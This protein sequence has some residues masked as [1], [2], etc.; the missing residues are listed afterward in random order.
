M[1]GGQQLESNELTVQNA[2]AHPKCCYE[3]SLKLPERCF[4]GLLHRL[5]TYPIL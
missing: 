4:S 1:A 2:F 5:L 3:E